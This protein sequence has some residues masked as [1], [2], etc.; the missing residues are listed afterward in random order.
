MGGNIWKNL[1]K[2]FTITEYKECED[3]LTK[4]LI[5]H[6]IIFKTIPYLKNKTSFGDIDV[7]VRL[8]DKK[9][10]VGYLN[11]QF[12]H[13]S[14]NNNCISALYHDCFQIDFILVP[15]PSLDYACNYF[16]YNDLGMLIGKI[17]KNINLTHGFNCLY[18]KHRH[19]VT[20]HILDTT[21]IYYDYYKTL[22]LLGLNPE[23]FKQGFNSEIEIFEY[24]LN[25]PYIDTLR[26]QLENLSNKDR[27]RNKKRKTYNMFLTY[28]NSNKIVKNCNKD[29]NF[30]YSTFPALENKQKALIEKANTKSLVKAKLNGNIISSYTGLTGKD[31]G[32]FIK[33]L[34]LSDR[35]I[36]M[37]TEE[38]IKECILSKLKT[39]KR[40]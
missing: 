34:N 12:N 11:T 6:G 4:D 22:E 30:P 28:I 19:P 7:V 14:F 17:A 40:L 1:S 21:P 2:R 37:N 36:L 3:K 33:H 15:S 39:Y 8:E 35:E 27:V 38:Y 5:D 26:L 16:S 20:N 18:Y 29:F 13:V 25:S 31:L 24:V 23:K 9:L 10:L 32:L